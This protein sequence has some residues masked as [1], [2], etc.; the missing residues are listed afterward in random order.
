[1]MYYA[2]SVKGSFWMERMLK[3]KMKRIPLIIK[4]IFGSF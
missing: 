3:T 1:M 2:Y 4:F